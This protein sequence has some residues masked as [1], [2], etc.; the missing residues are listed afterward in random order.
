M[1]KRSELLTETQ[2]RRRSGVRDAAARGR[3]GVCLSQAR[4]AIERAA[5]QADHLRDTARVARCHD[6][7]AKLDELVGDARV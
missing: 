1:T 7:L 4:G 5:V 3:F 6:L 2:T